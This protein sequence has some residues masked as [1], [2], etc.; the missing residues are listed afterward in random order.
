MQFARFEVIF[1]L[2]QVFGPVLHEVSSPDALNTSA[3]DWYDTIIKQ[4][5]TPQQVTA[6][7]GSWIDVRDVAL[8]HILSLEKPSAGG[9]RFII[10]SGNFV[11]QDWCKCHLRTSYPVTDTKQLTL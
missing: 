2:C 1:L 4:S 6:F 11:W 7:Q 5:K 9:Q 3:K 8:A 10:T